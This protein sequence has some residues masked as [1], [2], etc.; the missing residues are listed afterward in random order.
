MDGTLD[1]QGSG[2]FDLTTGVH[3]KLRTS[4]YK[5]AVDTSGL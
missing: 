5:A 3:G 1:D 4:A 2:V